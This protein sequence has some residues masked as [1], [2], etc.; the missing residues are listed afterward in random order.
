MNIQYGVMMS[1]SFITLGCAFGGDYDR[2]HEEES[3]G[4]S[5]SA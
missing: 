5:K 1:I 2:A 3:R 4:E